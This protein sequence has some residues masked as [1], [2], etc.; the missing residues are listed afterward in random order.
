MRRMARLT[1]PEEL[2]QGFAALL[3]L[4]APQVEE[5]A[6]ALGAL[7]PTNSRISLRANV[8][9]DVKSI[10]GPELNAVVDTLISLFS[11]RDSLGMATPE[12]TGTIADAVERSE[13]DQLA[14][15][16]AKARQTFEAVLAQLLEIE[17]L[18]VAAKAIGLAYEQD[19]IIHGRPR[20]LTDVRPI[21][22]SDPAKPDLRGA[23]VVHTLRVDYHEGARVEEL[24]LALDADELEELIEVLERAKLKGEALKRFLQGSDIHHVESE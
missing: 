6:S 17:S 3:D 21:F 7:R 11:L 9:S 14:F 10:E 23:M 8:A 19:H 12:F 1:I 16:D 24:F 13:P 20:V 15:P 5:L 4:E 22:G 2:R 18:E